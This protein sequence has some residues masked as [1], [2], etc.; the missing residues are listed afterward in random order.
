MAGAACGSGGGSSWGWDED[1]GS[2]G[3]GGGACLLSGSL[4]ARVK[5]WDA[6]T[7]AC[8]AT[9]KLPGPVVA[10]V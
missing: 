3:S 2:G 9:A 10:M 7:A 4:D 1:G 6:W 5:S 8:V